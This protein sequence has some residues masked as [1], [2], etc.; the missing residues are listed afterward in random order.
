MTP[1]RKEIEDLK[2]AVDL[3]ALF[4]AF[5]ME[6]RKQGRGVKALC[7]FHDEKTPSLS[8]DPKKGLYKCFGCGK[9]GDSLTFLQEHAKLSFAEAVAEL[10][11]HAGT[12]SAQADPVPI[13]KIEEEPFPYDLME[14]VAEIWHQAFCDSPEALEYLENR[15]IHDRGLLRELRV[16]YCNG[17]KLLAITNAEERRLL[18]SVGVLNEGGK[19]FFSRCVVFAL[20][21]RHNRVT[22]FYGR[23][24]SRDAKV[25]H[26]CCAGN[27]TGLFCVEAARGVSSVFLV[28]GVLDALALMQSGFSNTLALGGTQGLTPPWWSTCDTK[29]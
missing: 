16:G 14:R 1:P 26:R 8:I 4:Q 17:E 24:L 20:R 10:R 5:G 11:R 18:Q 9:A 29:T 7:P 3:V 23:S 28:E 13:T 22:G 19:E 2:A 15:G 12:Q 25:P 21:D 27:R 6:I